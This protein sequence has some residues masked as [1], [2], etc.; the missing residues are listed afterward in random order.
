LTF[1]FG[2]YENATWALPKNLRNAVNAPWIS[3]PCPFSQKPSS[4]LSKNSRYI[5]GVWFKKKTKRKFQN[6]LK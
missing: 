5:L 3:L 2:G 4:G 6:L 1:I